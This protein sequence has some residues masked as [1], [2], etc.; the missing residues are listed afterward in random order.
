M[1]IYCSFL[2]EHASDMIF[3]HALVLVH[4]RKHEGALHIACV[5][6][7]LV[8]QVRIHCHLARHDQLSSIILLVIRFHSLH[9][10]R[11]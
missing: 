9:T 2:G 3:E 8:G 11:S 5:A 10:R 6:H 4:A 1:V 7:R